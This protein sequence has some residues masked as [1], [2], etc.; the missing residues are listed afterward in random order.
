M[1][2]GYGMGFGGIF[3]WLFWILVIIGVV[4][5]VKLMMGGGEADS[6]PQRSALE[7]LKER[8]ARGEIDHEEFEQKRRDLEG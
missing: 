5:L 7:I 4:W 3:M 2:N 6:P 8:Y 1:G